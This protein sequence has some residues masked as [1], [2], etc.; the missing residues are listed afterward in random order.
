MN[1]LCALAVVVSLAAVGCAS[2]DE[3]P[4]S[5]GPDRSATANGKAD[6]DAASYSANY[7]CSG[8]T[9]DVWFQVERKAKAL[10]ALD[11]QG[12]AR[13][14][15]KSESNG[16]YKL[17]ADS[18]DEW[19][20]IGLMGSRATA[21]DGVFTGADSVTFVLLG[22]SS[23]GTYYCTRDGSG[24]PSSVDAGIPVPDAS[25]PPPPDASVV[26]SVAGIDL[27]QIELANDYCTTLTYQPGTSIVGM[28]NAVALTKYTVVRWVD[29]NGNALSSDVNVG[30]DGS[31]GNGNTYNTSL[32]CIPKIANGTMMGLVFSGPAGTVTATFPMGLT[33]QIT[34]AF[35][36]IGVTF[37]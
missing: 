28:A 23:T 8:G 22:G 10:Y 3:F 11:S 17:N 27:T 14:V 5:T 35:S 9:G 37:H 4:D 26:S 32:G 15:A 13:F 29:V 25:P 18:R 24:P 12:G 34:V 6:S 1:K 2:T 33:G 21:S 31:F 36:Q 16:V 19:T 30:P 20:N 7:K